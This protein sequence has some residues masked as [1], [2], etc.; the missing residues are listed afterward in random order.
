MLVVALVVALVVVLVVALAVAL[1]V[2][3]VFV[4]TPFVAVVFVMIPVNDAFASLL[5]HLLLVLASS[6]AHQ[7]ALAST[8]VA[9]VVESVPV[10]VSAVVAVGWPATFGWSGSTRPKR[11][12]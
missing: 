4:A 3:L 7:T 1:G 11:L 12:S 9:V 10:V 8:E 5:L 6:V 2:V